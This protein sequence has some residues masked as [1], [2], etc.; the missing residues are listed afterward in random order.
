MFKDIAYGQWGCKILG[1]S[2]LHNVTAQMSSWGYELPDSVLVFATWLG[3]VDI[4]LFDLQKYG[5]DKGN[6]MID[7]E[8]GIPLLD[9]KMIND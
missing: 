1:L 7:G 4:L 8:Q 2:E 5:E 3:D 6:Y 9:W